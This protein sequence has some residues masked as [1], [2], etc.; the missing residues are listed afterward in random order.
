[1]TR[2]Q[3]CN[4]PRGMRAAMTFEYFWYTVIWFSNMFNLFWCIF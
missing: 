2:R 4:D 1:M 3:H